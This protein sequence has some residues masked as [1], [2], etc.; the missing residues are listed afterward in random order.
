MRRKGARL[1][2]LG[3][4]L[5]VALA[6]SPARGQAFGFEN[7]VNGE[8]A[9][10]A[11]ML[12][13]HAK[14]IAK[15]TALINEAKLV[16]SNTNDV[17]SLARVAKRSVDVIRNYTWDQLRRD[18]E[19]GLGE[20][21]PELRELEAEVEILTRNGQALVQ[22][23]GSFFRLV[24][25]HDARARKLAVH[26]YQATLW[27]LVFPR[28]LKLAEAQPSPV[29]LLVQQRYRATQT[30][31]RRAYRDSVVA[32]L[33]KQSDAMWRDSMEKDN[34]QVRAEAL[35]A[36]TGVQTM[37]DTS[38]LLSLKEQEV[39]MDEQ[40]RVESQ[41]HRGAFMKLMADHPDMLVRPGGF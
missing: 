39:A 27:P 5:L 1:G 11:K 8:N 10:L 40:R 6:S 15:L 31:A 2:A 37:R 19:M 36:H 24:D 33:L 16:V 14:E 12:A 13:L 23:D 3:A 20:A 32:S 25:Y 38:E 26:A 41:A 35:A 30:E 29:E 22:N 18:A 34:L 17:L 28:A 21:F 7:W 4:A 9:M